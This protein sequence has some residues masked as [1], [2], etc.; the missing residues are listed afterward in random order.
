MPYELYDFPAVQSF[1][2]FVRLA[3]EDAARK[4]GLAGL[5]AR[6]V[7]SRVVSLTRL[8]CRDREYALRLGAMT[9]IK[10]DVRKLAYTVD[11]PH[12]QNVVLE[13][14]N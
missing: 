1:G 2:E 12:G 10:D 9:A 5:P 14:V 8:L 6:R 4:S 7:P 11:P 13:L 3:L